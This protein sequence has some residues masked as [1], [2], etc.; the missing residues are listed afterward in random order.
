MGAVIGS[1]R[2]R[3]SVQKK[4]TDKEIVLGWREILTSVHVSTSILNDHGCHLAKINLPRVSV[5][6]KMP[7]LT[8]FCLPKGDCLFLSMAHTR[9]P[10][11][12]YF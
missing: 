5:L 4:S 9:L 6:D 3:L 7:L 10:S 8:S 11:L 2:N 12:T 1:P